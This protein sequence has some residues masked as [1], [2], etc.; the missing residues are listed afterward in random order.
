MISAAFLSGV[1]LGLSAAF[2]P[3]GARH[4]RLLAALERA[5]EPMAA[6]NDLSALQSDWQRI[7]Q[8]FRRA[9]ETIAREL[10]AAR[11]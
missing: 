10:A 11:R 7:G 1:S 8:D 9:H 4:A 6:R 5:R 2:V 3:H